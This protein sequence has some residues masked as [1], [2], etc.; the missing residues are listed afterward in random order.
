[1]SRTVGV[2]REAEGQKSGPRGL[3]AERRQ[4]PDV[5]RPQVGG[6]KWAGDTGLSPLQLPLL[7]LLVDFSVWGPS[8]LHPRPALLSSY[9][10]CVGSSTPRT[11]DHMSVRVRF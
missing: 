6:G 8:G 5:G 1:M 3:R 4:E 7:A 9:S 11:P 10:C 2:K